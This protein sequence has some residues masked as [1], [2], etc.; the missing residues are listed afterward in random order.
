[1]T[2]PNISFSIVEPSVVADLIVPDSTIVPV[3]ISINDPTIND[4]VLV[5]LHI[6]LA[7]SEPDTIPVITAATLLA[8]SVADFDSPLLPPIISNDVNQSPKLRLIDYYADSILHP[9]NPRVRVPVPVP[10][11]A[12]SRAPFRANITGLDSDIA[13]GSEPSDTESDIEDDLG[14][15]RVHKHSIAL[16]DGSD[17]SICVSEC[18]PHD[19]YDNDGGNGGNGVIGGNGGKVPRNRS[20]IAPLPT[21]SAPSEPVKITYNKLSYND[22]RRQINKSY[23]Q[24]IVHRYSSALDILASY[25]K[26]QKIIYMEARYSTVTILNCLM[27]PC[28]FL[29]ALI[30]VI[31]TPLNATP[32]GN[33]V[34]SAISAF[35]AFILAIINYLRLDAASE[36]HKISSSKYDKLQANVEFQ[37]GHVLLFSDPLLTAENVVRQ[38]EEQ[39]KVIECSCP[40]AASSSSSSYSASSSASSVELAKNRAEWISTE[41]RKFIAKINTDRQAAESALIASMRDNIDNID[42]RI[43]EIKETNQFLIPRNIRYRYPLVYNTNV[44]SIIKKIDDYKAKTLTNLKN[45]KNEIR[46]IH[47]M[48]LNHK[49]QQYKQHLAHSQV[50]T[51]VIIDNIISTPFVKKP[52]PYI[53]RAKL[54]FKQKKNIIHTILFLNT[55]FSMIDKMFQQE[56]TNAKLKQENTCFRFTLHNLFVFLC[57]TAAIRCCLPEKYID[58]EK[59]GGDILQ[60]LMGFDKHID[61]TDDDIDLILLQSREKDSSFSDESSV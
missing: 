15:R 6:P 4:P 7:A 44:F 50:N 49:Q 21:A 28:I 42:K 61:I 47:A 41:E 53:E 57:P 23:E 59:C 39:R 3:P 19:G 52:L 1:M 13:A 22:V 55:A 10:V 9:A 2:E 8:N 20:L 29:S 12:T 17:G 25:L 35:I 11:H 46:Y 24:D 26:G 37:S 60:K 14:T 33:Y 34:I 38:W 36:A 45:V 32:Y 16:A 40:Y 56:I 5:S 51:A 58:P 30:S 27:L 54:L 43:A 18:G 31:Q 48:Q